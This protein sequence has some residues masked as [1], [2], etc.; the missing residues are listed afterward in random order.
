MVT[1]TVTPIRVAIDHD[2]FWQ[3]AKGHPVHHNVSVF[4]ALRAEGIPVEGG[5]EFRGVL[6]GRISMWNEMRDGRRFCIYEWTP[7]DDSPEPE[8]ETLW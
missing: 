5:L 1:T 7:G 6:H 3:L 2:R 8:E 4:N